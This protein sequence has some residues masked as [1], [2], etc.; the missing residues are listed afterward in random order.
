MHDFPPVPYVFVA[1]DVTCTNGV[2]LF[3][4]PS[5][6]QLSIISTGPYSRAQSLPIIGAVSSSIRRKGSGVTLANWAILS[7]L[8][9][10]AGFLDTAIGSKSDLGLD[11]SYNLLGR[12]KRGLSGKDRMFAAE[13]DNSGI[14]DTLLPRE[15]VN[16]PCR[17]PGT[18]L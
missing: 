4:R 3:D 18:M 10:W 11:P 14:C 17:F 6:R 5:L 13:R 7:K 8:F 9:L 1:L 12:A 15:T 2:T 16:L